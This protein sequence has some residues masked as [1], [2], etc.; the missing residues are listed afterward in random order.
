MSTI[1]T[2]I[3]SLRP[4]GITADV[5]KSSLPVISP[6]ALEPILL[7]GARLDVS[8]AVVIV[9]EQVDVRPREPLLHLAVHG[10][11]RRMVTR[12]RQAARDGVAQRALRR[13]EVAVALG[14]RAQ[15]LGGEGGGAVA[16]DGHDLVLLVEELD[17]LG[18][19][20]G[21]LLDAEEDEAAVAVDVV[22]GPLGAEDA[23]LR[24]RSPEPLRDGRFH[25]ADSALRVRGRQLDQGPALAVHDEVAAVL[26]ALGDGDEVVNGLALAPGCRQCWLLAG[27]QQ[28]SEFGMDDVYTVEHHQV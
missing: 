21:V 12:R 9:A 18:L 17:V 28:A 11:P 6:L 2:T 25:L 10:V 13:G 16:V 14:E 7:R 5:Q 26:A 22:L 23:G 19:P 4:S 27:G 8:I 3:S 20:L 24:R 1:G 15:Q